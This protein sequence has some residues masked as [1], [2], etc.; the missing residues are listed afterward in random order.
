MSNH[1]RRNTLVP[2]YK[3]KED[4]QDC[5]NYRGIKL[6]SH[7]IKLWERAIEIRIRRC[8]SIS[9]NQFGFIIRRSTTEAIHLTRQMMEY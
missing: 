6:I 2:I 7:T 4:V 9:E 8:T 1:W 3:N 5:S